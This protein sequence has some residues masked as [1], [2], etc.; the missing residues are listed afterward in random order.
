MSSGQ[1]KGELISE[2]F[3]NGN[4]VKYSMKCLVLLATCTFF[5]KMARNQQY[6]TSSS[7]WI[8]HMA[9][10]FIYVLTTMHQKIEKGYFYNAIIALFMRQLIVQYVLNNLIVITCH[11]IKP[12][13][14]YKIRGRYVKFLILH[15]KACIEKIKNKFY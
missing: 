14:L 4:L 10:S 7:V 11:V 9:Y 5:L 6:L 2:D 1:N 3:W 13:G 12:K 15:Q 8:N